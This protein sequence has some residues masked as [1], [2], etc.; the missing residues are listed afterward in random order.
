MEWNDGT[1]TRLLATPPRLATRHFVIGGVYAR[2]VRAEATR[3]VHRKGSI[4]A[5]LTPKTPLT[6]V[7]FPLLPFL[8][9]LSSPPSLVPLTPPPGFH[10]NVRHSSTKQFTG[11]PPFVFLSLSSSFLKRPSFSLMLRAT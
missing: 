7:S 3:E 9:S 4:L 2:A 5:H 8:F 1:E 6:L 11:L 10:K